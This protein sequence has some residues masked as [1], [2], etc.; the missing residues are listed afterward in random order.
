MGFVVIISSLVILYGEDYIHD[1]LNLTHFILLVL[2]FVLVLLPP[3][4]S[5]CNQWQYQMCYCGAH[6]LLRT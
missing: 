1:D 5:A 4:C 3:C 6:W 2:M